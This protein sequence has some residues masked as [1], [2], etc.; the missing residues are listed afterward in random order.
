MIQRLKEAKEKHLT[1]L[2]DELTRVKLILIEMG[3]Q[4]I[5]LFGSSIRGELGLMSDI[6]LLVVIESDKDFIE[7]LSYFYQ[8]IQPIDIDILIY[9]PCEFLRM[10]EENLFIQ[11]IVKK[12]KIIFERV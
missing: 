2:Q 9:T 4:K 12:G 6:D 5:I 8:K 11:H 10:M 7:R 1:N 3:A